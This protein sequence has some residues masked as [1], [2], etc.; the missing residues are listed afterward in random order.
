MEVL[1]CHRMTAVAFPPLNVHVGSPGK[2]LES[3]EFI[4]MTFGSDGHPIGLTVMSMPTSID[5]FG[6]LPSKIS[7]CITRS[8]VSAVNHIVVNLRFTLIPTSSLQHQP[9]LFLQYSDCI[10]AQNSHKWSILSI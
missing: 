1:L 2:Y 5:P 10:Y 3:P 7:M 4:S 9:L 8:P 6:V